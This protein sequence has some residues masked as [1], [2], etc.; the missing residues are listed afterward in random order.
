MTQTRGGLAGT[1]PDRGER[2]GARRNRLLFCHQPRLIA[3][4]PSVFFQFFSLSLTLFTV[5]SPSHSLTPAGTRSSKWSFQQR[6][7]R[8]VR[9]EGDQGRV[10]SSRRSTDGF[11]VFSH[12]NLFSLPKKKKKKKVS[13]PAAS[14]SPRSPSTA[15]TAPLSSPRRQRPCPCLASSPRTRK[16]SSSSN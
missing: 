1:L 6:R 5:H 15:P 3:L 14:P 10:C 13:T 16:G 9:E 12:L 7:R 11:F 2:K 4:M 8:S